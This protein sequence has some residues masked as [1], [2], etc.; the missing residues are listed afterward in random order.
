MPGW[1][2]IRAAR[3]DDS[4]VPVRVEILLTQRQMTGPSAT[5]LLHDFWT[6]AAAV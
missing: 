3:P 4:L 6:Y 1:L 2:H 5:S